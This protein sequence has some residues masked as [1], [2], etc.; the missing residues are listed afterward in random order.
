MSDKDNNKID[1]IL[2]N[3]QPIATEEQRE[4]LRGILKNFMPLVSRT[5][6]SSE[7]AGKFREALDS[8]LGE[9]GPIYREIT[10]DLLP[11]IE[12]E[13]Q[14]PEYNGATLQSLLNEYEIRDL[15]HLPEDSTLLHVIRAA[16]TARDTAERVT[17]RRADI[18]EYPLDKPNTRIWN[19]LETGNNGQLSIDFDML[20]K[21]PKLQAKAIYS[22][23]FSALADDVRITKKLQPFDKF[24]YMAVSALYNAGNKVIS[25]S[26][27]YY[28]MGYTGTPG[29][30]DRKK[31]NDSLTKMTSAKI[32]FDN[33]KEAAAVK[34]YMHFKYDGS[35]LPFER[36][37]AVVNGQ[38]TESAVK[39]FREPPL[40]SFAKQRKQITT[41]DIKLLQSPISKTDINL[42]IQ[43][44]LLERISKAKDK[45]KKSKSKNNNCRILFKTLYERL[46][47]SGS[48]S[49]EK[50]QRKRTPDKVIK[51]LNSY[52]EKNFIKRHT[53][54]ADGITIYY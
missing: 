10:G 14:K 2:F 7:N 23:D 16:R 42:A 3:I 26:Q 37:T 13:L 48:T 6:N 17:V 39:P 32:F 40:M 30:K 25:L 4:A 43:D 11:Y 28:A 51:L 34:G 8:I 24:V 20:P 54:Q 53:V 49:K 29:E 46:N 9:S 35:L 52:Q 15:A 22:I 50:M 41:I 5:I 45:A 21:E 33:E 38:I 44:Y 47:I 18:I 31:I 36:I 19:L 27:I 1:E 12:K